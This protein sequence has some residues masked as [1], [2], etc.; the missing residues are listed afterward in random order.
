[1]KQAIYFE[2]A[3]VVAEDQEKLADD[4]GLHF[5]CNNL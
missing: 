4:E 1:M 3:A 2:L 5:H